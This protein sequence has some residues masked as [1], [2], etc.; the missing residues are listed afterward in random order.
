MTEVRIYGLYSSKNPNNIRYVGKTS[1]SL[2]KRLSRHIQSCEK[3]KTRK[4]N[5]IK[6]ELK[7]GNKILIIEIFEVPKND[8]WEK[9]EIYFISEYKKIGHKLTNSTIGGEDLQGAN[10]PFFGKNHTKKSL[11][12][13]RLS[14]PNRKEI[15][16]YDLKG[17]LLNTFDSI[18]EASKK[19]N[20]SISS[21]SD[22]CKQKPKYR[23]AGG[24]VWRYK[25]E[26]FS[27]EYTN[28]AKHLRKSVCQYNKEGKLIKEFKSVSEA[29]TTTNTSSGNIS[30]CCNKEIKSIGGYIWRFKGDKF[31]YKNTRKD[32]KPVIQYTLNGA[33]V[34][35]FKSISEASDKTNIC[36]TGIYCCCKGKYTNSGGYKWKFS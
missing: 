34:K 8:N 10:N 18:R 6:K 22:V 20:I 15:N 30:R 5:W 35:E 25:D 4:S 7:N 31:S 33:F 11:K 1:E 12:L 27:L 19:I 28:P 3:E 29:A 21:I 17:N 13:N 14:Q 32:A 9:W 23:T 2:N 26:L 16:Q 24:Y 36:H